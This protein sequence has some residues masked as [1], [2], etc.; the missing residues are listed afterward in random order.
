MSKKTIT[1]YH[2]DRCGKQIEKEED[3]IFVQMYHKGLY[4]NYD[5][6]VTC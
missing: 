5:F 2:C 1:V 6:C 3:H 4:E